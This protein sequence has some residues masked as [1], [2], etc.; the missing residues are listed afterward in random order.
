MLDRNVV[1]YLHE[2]VAIVLCTA[3]F[4][5]TC[6]RQIYIIIFRFNATIFNNLRLC[7]QRVTLM[8]LQLYLLCVVVAAPSYTI[9]G[10]ITIIVCWI[11]QTRK[12]KDEKCICHDCPKGGFTLASPSNSYCFVWYSIHLDKLRIFSL[13]FKT[14]PFVICHH[15]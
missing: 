7:K 12:M 4:L 11:L 10:G 3:T 2:L 6:R 13:G 14:A 1:E 8:C 15:H 9:V 5:H